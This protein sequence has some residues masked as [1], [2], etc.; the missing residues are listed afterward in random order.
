MLSLRKEKKQGILSQ[1]RKTMQVKTGLEQLSIGGADI[2]FR[3]SF[4]ILSD[5]EKKLLETLKE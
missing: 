3:D 2:D 1:R 5:P 4:Q